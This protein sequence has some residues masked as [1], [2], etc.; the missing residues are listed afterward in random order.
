MYLEISKVPCDL[1]WVSLVLCVF[2]PKIVGRDDLS[3]I[4]HKLKTAG[5]RG[6]GLLGY[7]LTVC[8]FDG[9]TMPPVTLDS[10]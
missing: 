9:S 6:E 4:G 7:T 2:V 3:C 10:R 5:R 1:F 8:R